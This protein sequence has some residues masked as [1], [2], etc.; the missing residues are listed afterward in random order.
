[1]RSVS[2]AGLV[3]R[4]RLPVSRKA[5]ERLAGM[6]RLSFVSST[7]FIPAC[8]RLLG[9]EL[10]Q[11]KLQQKAFPLAGEVGARKRAGSGTNRLPGAHSSEQPSDYQIARA[12]HS[13]HPP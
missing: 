4:S 7:G 11:A 10:S 13:A 2:R 1:M 12:S 9:H 5:A 8:G 3:G 6:I